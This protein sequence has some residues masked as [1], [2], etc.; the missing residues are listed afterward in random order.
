MRSCTI[1]AIESPWNTGT[2][3]TQ[4][5]A[6]PFYCWEALYVTPFINWSSSTSSP[7]TFFFSELHT[8]DYYKHSNFHSRCINCQFNFLKSKWSFS[9]NNFIVLIKSTLAVSVL[10]TP[11][12]W[13]TLQPFC[14][15][16]HTWVYYNHNTNCA[17][18]SR[19]ISLVPYPVSLIL[20]NKHIL[21][22]NLP[23]SRLQNIPVFSICL[24]VLHCQQ[25][26]TELST[27]YAI[28][29]RK[30]KSHES[31]ERSLR[32]PLGWL[33]FGLKIYILSMPL[34]Y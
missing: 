12:L 19:G 3:N 30:L 23:L 31:C 34:V 26:S 10:D 21:K 2:W 6:T 13:S 18:Y 33:L 5:E 20:L 28:R 17:Q 29:T 1:R 4:L 11:F 9:L 32:S 14:A 8:C 22:S 7:A 25:I 15:S 16:T 27:F 24:L